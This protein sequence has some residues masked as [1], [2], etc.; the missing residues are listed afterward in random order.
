MSSVESDWIN[1]YGTPKSQQ[2]IFSW[3]VWFKETKV[4][5]LP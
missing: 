5:Q 3:N 4:Q 1:K 2:T